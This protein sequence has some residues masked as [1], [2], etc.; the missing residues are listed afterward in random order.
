M[1]ICYQE[2]CRNTV[3][4]F[5]H[6]IETKKR[7]FSGQTGLRIY[8]RLSTE[9]Y[10]SAPYVK[11]LLCTEASLQCDYCNRCHLGN[12][13]ESHIVERNREFQLNS[14]LKRCIELKTHW[15]KQLKLKFFV[16]ILQGGS[17]FFV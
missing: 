3:I 11:T 12:E 14:T 6:K 16:S 5:S 1:E 10:L 7:I 4:L 2:T 9:R 8:N 13:N 15:L 17:V